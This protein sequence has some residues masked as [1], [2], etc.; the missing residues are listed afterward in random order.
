MSKTVTWGGRERNLVD[1][2]NSEWDGLVAGD[3][4]PIAQWRLRQPALEGCRDLAHILDCIAERSDATLGALLSEHRRGEQLAGRVVL[5]AMLGK[6][7]RMAS[8]D[9]RGGVDEYVSA[10]WVRICDYP[11]AARP[12]KIAANLALDTL[13]M[14]T[15]ERRPL[16]RGEV[17][18]YPPQAFLQ[19]MF[20]RELGRQ[21]SAGTTDLDARSVIRAAIHLK[22][23]NANSAAALTSVYAEGLSGIEAARSLGSS[24]TMVRY[25]CSTTVARLAKHAVALAA[26]A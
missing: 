12:S 4:E 24:P 20:A 3:Q 23:I 8:R 1:A 6:V 26:A 14:V 25:R 22:L 13:K 17:T 7:V 21:W 18:P 2:L 19:E 5:Q 15:E 10:M 16:R 9:A 11:L